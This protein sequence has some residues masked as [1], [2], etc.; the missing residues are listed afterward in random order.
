MEF[1]SGLL[2]GAMISKFAIVSIIIAVVLIAGIIALGIWG[3]K[4][5]KQQ[6]ES[7]QQ[8]EAAKQ[9]VKLLVID[10]KRMKLKDANMP[11]VVMEN[12]P[13]RF[14]NQKLPIV[15]AKVGPQIMSL[16]CE[17]QIFDLIPVKKEVRASISGIYILEVKGIHSS[18][19]AKG[20]KISFRE[21]VSAKAKSLSADI[22]TGKK[23]DSK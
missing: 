21:K 4:L 20:R 10:K 9:S 3:K 23:K 8:L 11:A 19:E 16:I 14:Q 17:E 6:D 12:V 7:R 15:K 2:L 18:L 22:A 13:K 1:Y 5:Q